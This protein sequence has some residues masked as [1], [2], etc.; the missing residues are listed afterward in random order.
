MTAA[1]ANRYVVATVK[2]WNL[3]AYH[4]HVAA[5]PGAWTLI[6]RPEDL[7]PERLAALEPRYVFLPHWSWIV[8]PE[9]TTAF[10]CVCFHMTDVPYG[11]GGSP[12]QNLIRRGHTDT[13]LTALRMTSELDAGPVYLKRPLSLAGSAQEIFER[14]ADLAAVMIGEIAAAEPVPVP[15]QGDVVRFRRRRPGQSLLPA[16]VDLDRIADHIRMLDADTYPRAFLDHGPLRLEFAT[17]RREGATVRA[18]VTIRLR[19][20]DDPEGL[21]DDDTPL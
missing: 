2:A 13:V 14:A 8:P 4:R 21:N 19:T 6:E 18:E 12:L 5:W 1:G 10:E 17:A 20:E 9:I 11:R 7:T 16:T 15:Q 3:D